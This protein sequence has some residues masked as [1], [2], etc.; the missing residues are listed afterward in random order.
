[1]YKA[2]IAGF[3]EL[4]LFGKEV[5]KGIFKRCDRDKDGA[6]SFDEMN[7]LQVSLSLPLSL[8]LSLF[9]SLSLLTLLSLLLLFL[10][11]E[12]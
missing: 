11:R 7:A 6:L 2:E 1:L 4:S 8:S 3:G 12:G 9:S 10:C 5:V